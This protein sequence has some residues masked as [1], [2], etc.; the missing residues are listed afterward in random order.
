MGVGRGCKSFAG[1]SDRQSGKHSK[2]YFG[3]HSGVHL[4]APQVL[5]KETAANVSA[6]SSDGVI[7]GK[8]LASITDDPRDSPPLFR[9][10]LGIG[11]GFE[12]KLVRT[13]PVP[14]VHRSKRV[15][16]KRR[17]TII[18]DLGFSL[19]LASCVI[20]DISPDGFRLR[21]GFPL[22]RGHRVE[23]IAHEGTSAVP[24]RVVWV[25]ARGSKYDGEAGLQTAAS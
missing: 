17:A 15:V 14:D 7:L 3:Q 8:S 5:Y 9:T 11:E 16:T 21:T 6:S 22:R 25:G 23:V 1:L 4:I 19:E 2:P 18:V 24:C 12:Q 13:I 20:L 10:Q